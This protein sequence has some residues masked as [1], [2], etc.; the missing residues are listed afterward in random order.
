MFYE[1]ILSLLIRNE[2]RFAVVGGVAVVLHGVMRFTNDLD[3]IVDL[4]QENVRR[5]LLAMEQLHYRPRLAVDAKL[6]AD[7]KVRA[8]WMV[9]RNLKA[10]TFWNPDKQYREVDI[11]LS[12]SENPDFFK[13]ATVVSAGDLQVP[14][15][16]IEDL[17]DM[18][19]RAGRKRD[20]DDVAALRE[21]RE[22][23]RIDYGIR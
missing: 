14:V 12:E 3:I 9:N 2:V 17:I 23:S 8:D 1:Q 22:I 21:V 7:P 10:F 20:Y 16:S 4:E 15:V 6:V 11:L 19:L 5:L 13:R 18:K